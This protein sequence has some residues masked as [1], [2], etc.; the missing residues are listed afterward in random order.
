MNPYETWK[1]TERTL[2]FTLQVSREFGAGK[3]FDRIYILEYFRLLANLLRIGC[4][5]VVC[6]WLVIRTEE[7]T[8]R[9]LMQ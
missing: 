7:K 9:G 5:C 2:A 6:T 4:V 1:A 8:F 3:L